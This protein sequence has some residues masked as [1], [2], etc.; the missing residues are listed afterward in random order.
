MD[1]I[2][3][4]RA[5]VSFHTSPRLYAVRQRF[6]PPLAEGK[7]EWSVKEDQDEEEVEE[8]QDYRLEGSWPHRWLERSSK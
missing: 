4:S 6:I 3:E 1:R 7:E 2:E 8:E 5:L